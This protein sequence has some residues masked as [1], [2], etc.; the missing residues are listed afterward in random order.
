MVVSD[1]TQARDELRDLV[2]DIDDHIDAE[3][4][5]VV[6]LAERL[7]AAGWVKAGDTETEWGV[8]LDAGGTDIHASRESATSWVRDHHLRIPAKVV[9]RMPAGPWRVVE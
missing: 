4:E 1:T 7:L 6:H 2:Q 3:P 5:D 9:R 8:Q